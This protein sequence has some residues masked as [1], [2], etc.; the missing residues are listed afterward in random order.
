MA[1]ALD[2]VG[3]AIELGGFCR[4]GLERAFLEERQPPGQQATA[5][6]EAM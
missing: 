1:Q 4:I 6:T 5:G 3:A 2:Q